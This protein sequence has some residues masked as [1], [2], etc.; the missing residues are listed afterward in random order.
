MT[1]TIFLLALCGVALA[2]VTLL[3]VLSQLRRFEFSWTVGNFG[4]RAVRAFFW[5]GFIRI[6]IQC[7]LDFAV[8]TMLLYVISQHKAVIGAASILT[9]ILIAIPAVMFF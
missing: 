5:N 7:Y 8:T 3:A 6:I 9:L 2:I 4:R 1:H